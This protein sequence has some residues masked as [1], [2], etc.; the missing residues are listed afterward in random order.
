MS[1]P[2]TSNPQ[3]GTMLKNMVVDGFTLVP[4]RDL[5]SQV[6]N[7]EEH[8]RAHDLRY[9]FESKFSF[10]PENELVIVYLTVTASLKAASEATGKSEVDSLTMVAKLNVRYEYAVQDMQ[11]YFEAG[12][13]KNHLP[14][15]FYIT[16]QSIS[17][18]TARGIFLEKTSG[19]YLGPSFFGIIDP[20]NF[21]KN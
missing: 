14:E 11:N 15:L 7:V 10:E 6:E 16:L 13:M 21:R 8:L 18:S 5:R 2:T 9:N 1:T 12:S 4:L 3:V 17:V 20:K 19:T